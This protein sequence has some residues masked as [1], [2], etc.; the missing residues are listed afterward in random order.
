MAVTLALLGAAAPVP[1]LCAAGFLASVGLTCGDIIWFTTFQLH[2]PDH[3]MA[4]LSSFDWFGSVAL[5][6]VGYALIGPL[7]DSLGV[8]KTLYLAAALNGAI[9][10]VVALTPAVRSLGRAPATAT[11][12]VG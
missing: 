4:R 11:A 1:L 7:A 3:L 8:A 12:T 2:V 9:S 5:N 6:P 10:I